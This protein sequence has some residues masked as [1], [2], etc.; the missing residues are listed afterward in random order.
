[1][2]ISSDR[3][4]RLEDELA[5]TELA[6]EK[7]TIRNERLRDHIMVMESLNHEKKDIHSVH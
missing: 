3:A 4:S 2:L 1:M 5:K 7:E 6:F